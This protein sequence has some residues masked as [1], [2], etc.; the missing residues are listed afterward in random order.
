MSE[1]KLSKETR[2]GL[3]SR[4]RQMRTSPTPAEAQLWQFLR[5]QQLGGYKFRRQHRIGAYIV[6]FYCPQAKLV[7]ELD[8]EI[9]NDQ[10]EYDQKR[11][12]D[13]Q[14]LG[15]TVIRFKNQT[16]FSEIDSVLATILKSIVNIQ[17]PP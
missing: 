12:D 10:K 16:V 4:A 17:P 15:Y 6:D 14:A 2:A 9:H 8:G 11:Q 3:I 1:K 7:I 13:L 5:K